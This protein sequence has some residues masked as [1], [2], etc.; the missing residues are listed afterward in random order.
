MTGEVAGEVTGEVLRL[1]KVMAFREPMSRS[2][3]QKVLGLKGQANFRDRHL[4]PALSAG[5]VEMILPAKPRSSKQRYR[6]TARGREALEK[7]K[8]R[9]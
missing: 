5:L 4:V 7:A 8:K 9:K 6:I 1:L 3:A 2:Q